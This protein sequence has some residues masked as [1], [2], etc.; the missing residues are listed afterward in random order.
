METKHI[1]A[2]I[3]LVALSCGSVL[4]ATFWQRLR[5][6]AFV[7]MVAG[8]VLADRFDVQFFGQYWYRGTARG[9]GISLVDV[10][11]FAVLASTLLAPRYPRR[12]WFIPASFFLYLAYFVYC[13]FSVASAPEWRYGIWELANIPRALLIMLAGAAYVRTRRELALI[14]LGLGFAVCV[15]ALYASKQRFLGGMFRAQGTLDHANS[16][17]MYLCLVAPVLLAAGLADF[18]KHLR[19]FALTCSALAALCVLMTLSRAGLPI[20]GFVMFGVAVACTRWRITKRKVVLTLGIALA[21]G[22]VLLKSWDQLTARYGQASLA[23]EVLAMDGENRGIYWRWASMMVD[24]KPFGQGLNNWSYVVSKTYGGRVGFGYEDYDEIKTAPEKADIPSIRY[25][26][27]AHALAPLTLGELGIPGAILFLIVWLRWF[28]VGAMFLWR[29]LESDPM[30][31]LGI[32]FLF[33]ALG[34]FMQSVT[35]WT[36]RQQ[37]LFLPFHL[38]M[39]ALASLHYARAHAKVPVEVP[40]PE[41]VEFDAEPIAVSRIRPVR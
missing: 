38:M 28:Q 40:V 21:S 4:L 18:H 6:I 10:L 30:H 7:G 26:P 5:D 35:E 15:Q 17:S 27:P 9:V 13:A 41:E 16:L 20:F 32:G 25:A 29:R 22:V 3:V 14:V 37:G 36:Y 33:G 12:A 11:A 39:G 2:L 34:I 31:R 24:D 23:E 1:I 19:W 8:T